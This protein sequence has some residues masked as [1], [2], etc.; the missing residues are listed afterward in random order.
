MDSL[1][2]E[3]CRLP[4]RLATE[5]FC[6]SGQTADADRTW[7]QGVWELCL[8]KVQ[9]AWP[10]RHLRSHVCELI[11]QH[12]PLHQRGHACSHVVGLYEVWYERPFLFLNITHSL[13]SVYQYLALS[14]LFEHITCDCLGTAV[15]SNAWSPAWLS[16][17]LFTSLHVLTRGYLATMVSVR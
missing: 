15:T 14:L 4:D 5:P 1:A 6:R 16:L 10:I 12:A 11:Y 13:L 9:G 17:S 3:S 7:S 2:T 8:S